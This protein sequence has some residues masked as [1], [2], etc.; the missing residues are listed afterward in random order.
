MLLAHFTLVSVVPG[1]FKLTFRF[2]KLTLCH[3]H[4]TG[5]FSREP[6]VIVYDVHDGTDPLKKE[7]TMEVKGNKLQVTRSVPDTN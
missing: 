4:V 5:Q 1:I 2:L 6:K 7:A 3:D